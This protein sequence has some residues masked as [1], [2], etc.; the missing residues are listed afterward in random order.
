MATSVRNGPQAPESNPPIEPQFFQPS[1]FPIQNINFSPFSKAITGITNANP[2]VVTSANHGLINGTSVVIKSVGGMTQINGQIV[3]VTVLTANTFSIGV[4]TTAYGVYTSGGTW[5]LQ[6]PQGEVIVQMGTSFG[7]SNNYVIGQL[8]RLTI[9]FTFGARQL[10]GQSG[11]VISIPASNQV[12]VSGVNTISG[13]DPFIASPA[14]G[15]TPPQITAIGDV[16]SGPTNST[17]IPINSRPTNQTIQQQ[18][19]I[20]GSFINISPL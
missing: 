16:N 18:T 9:P 14:Y 6:L 7:V 3:T 11:Y 10:S 1:A 5:T 13:I 15:P 8:V 19:F 2:G 4:N 12:I 20:N 17:I